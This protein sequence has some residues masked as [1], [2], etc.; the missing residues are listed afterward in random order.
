MVLSSKQPA[1][2][3]FLRRRR[4]HKL[5]LNELNS[6]DPSSDRRPPPAPTMPTMGNRRARPVGGWAGTSAEPAA[7]RVAAS[8]VSPCRRRHNI[9]VVVVVVVDVLTALRLTVLVF[10][11]S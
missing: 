5:S 7:T 10:A 2:H 3:R 6:A 1:W 9:V 11:R 8:S 4:H